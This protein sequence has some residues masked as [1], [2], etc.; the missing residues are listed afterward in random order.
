MTLFWEPLA[1]LAGTDYLV[2]LHLTW[3]DD[4]HP[5]TQT[6]GRPMEGGQPTSRWTKPHVLFHDD[7]TIPL[8]ADLRP[9]RY[10]LR[11]GVYRASDGSRLHAETRAP[12][13]DD[14]IVLGEV[15]IVAP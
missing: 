6:D 11:M 10:V 12:V 9:G 1:N 3:T 4:P 8:P 15:Q 5:L 14:A 2:F 7:R 13:L